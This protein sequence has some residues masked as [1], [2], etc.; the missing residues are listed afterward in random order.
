[1][2]WFQSLDV[3]LFRF[4]NLTLSNPLFDR[5]MPFFS[6]NSLFVPLLIVLGAI[7]IWKAGT[8]GR[9]CVVMVAL[10]VGLGDPLVVNTIKHAVGRPRPFKVIADAHVPPRIGK[11]DSFSMPSGHT[12]NWFAATVVLLVYFP[13][14]IRFMLPL[15]ATIGFSRIYNGVHYPGDVLVGAALGAVYAAA[16]VWS[17]DALWRWVGQ[18]WFPLWWGRL[19]SLMHPGTGPEPS[20]VHAEQPAIGNPQLALEQHWLRLGYGVI[21]ILLLIR[22]AYLASGKIELSEDEAYQWLW[23][24]HLALSYYSKPPLIAYTQFL[25][26]TIWGDNEFGVRF[27]SPVIAATLSFLLLRFFAREVSAR[28]GAL[29][30]LLATATPLLAVGATLMTIDPLS[31]LF[32]AAAMIS[33][34]RAVQQGAT[35]HWLWT[36]LWM[37]LGFLGKYTALFQWLCWGVFFILWKPARAQLKRPGPYLALLVNALCALPVLVW[38]AQHGWI[39]VTHLEERGGLHTQWLPTLQFLGDFVLAEFGLLHPVFLV[40]AVWAS[41]AFWKRSRQNDLLIYFFSMGAPLFAFYLLYT[42]RARVQPN[43]IAPSVL[44]LLCLMAVYWDSRWREGARAVKTWLAFGLISGLLAVVVLHETNLVGRIFGWT[45]PPKLD[46]LRRVRAYREMAQ[47]VGEA[48]TNL[49][50]EGKPVFIIGN[51]Y[52]ITSLITFY[53]PEAKGG[54]PS[55]PLVYCRSSDKAENQF[56]FWPG[57]ERRSGEN[58]IFVQETHTPKPM[59]E[60]IQKEFATVTDL[61][62]HDI[63]YHGRVFHQIQLFECRHLR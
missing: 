2:S 31:V 16:L 1:M 12:A 22:L 34:W 26:T 50:A 62:I 44:P 55:D 45:L 30:V 47:V 61:G 38:N 9:I 39:T 53:L 21:G 33:G 51:H 58:A 11:T 35:R 24:K 14:S 40:A 27:F 17:L 63:K 36:G 56:Y 10:V 19:P 60:Q 25:G 49:L 52:G 37:G 43:W 18:R 42:L 32:W 48:R 7:L 28:I 8:R 46:P 59:P 54:V 3:A 23:S 20:G 15:A 6:G 41:I 5:L 13:R 29:L 4:I 57:Y